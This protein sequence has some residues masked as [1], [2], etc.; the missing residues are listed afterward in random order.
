MCREC[1]ALDILIPLFAKYNNVDIQNEEN[2]SKG[3][4]LQ[5]A[6]VQEIEQ[7]LVK[8]SIPSLYRIFK[9][10]SSK[11]RWLPPETG[12]VMRPHRILLIKSTV[13]KSIGKFG[14]Q[15]RAGTNDFCYRWHSDFVL[16]IR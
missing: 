7:V 11:K 8:V 16:Y 12:H 13:D 5:P 6:A 4:P 14:Y 3:V 1:N 2:E 10:A 9:T 15:P